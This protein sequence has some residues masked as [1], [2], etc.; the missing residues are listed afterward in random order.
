MSSNSENSES[1]YDDSTNENSNE[2]FQ[3]NREKNIPLEG[4]VWLVA[5]DGSH[6]SDRALKQASILINKHIDC[7]ILLH[8][9]KLGWFSDEKTL[10]Q[11]ADQTILRKYEEEVKR[12]KPEIYTWKSILEASNNPRQELCLQAKKLHAD[13]LVLGA[14]GISQN[15]QRGISES[16][17]RNRV[18]ESLGSMSD[19][20]A[21]YSPCNVII[22]KE[23]KPC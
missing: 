18:T 17:D 8:I 7:L 12:W 23:K 1:D 5:V 20:C 10:K 4:K 3:E 9:V 14:S 19:Y 16:N 22:V 13:Y 15:H 2:N 11:D 21:K 6:G